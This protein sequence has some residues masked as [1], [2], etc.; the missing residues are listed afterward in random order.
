MRTP[1]EP[2]YELLERAWS[3]L[4]K[5]EWGSLAQA[6]AG[7]RRFAIV[8]ARANALAGGYTAPAPAPSPAQPP[9]PV[10][11]PALRGTGAQRV[12]HTEPFLDNKRR[13][14]GERDDD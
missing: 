8:K 5:P 7:A 1:A 2:S 13:A 12:P 4:A 10:H 6:M 14:A 9:V 3:E 11:T